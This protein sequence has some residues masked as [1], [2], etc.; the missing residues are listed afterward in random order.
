MQ[1][2]KNGDACQDMPWPVLF[3]EMD[4]MYPSAK[5]ILME[6]EPDK[7]LDSIIKWKKDRHSDLDELVYGFGKIPGNEEVYL[8]RYLEHNKEVKDY[9]KNRPSKLLILNLEA[10]EGW[11]E[12]CSFLGKRVPKT[13]FPHANKS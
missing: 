11:D 2:L 6:R 4:R 1:I 9:F 3:K 7:W 13:A 10:N 5:F 12:I 8:N